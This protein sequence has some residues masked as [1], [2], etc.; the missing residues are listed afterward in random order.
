MVAECDIRS[1]PRPLL[2]AHYSELIAAVQD[3]DAGVPLGEH[4]NELKTYKDRFAGVLC[5]LSSSKFTCTKILFVACE[6]C[7][8]IEWLLSW[9]FVTMREEGCQLS[10]SLLNEA[11][12]QPVGGLNKESFKKHSHWKKLA[13]VDGVGAFYRF[14]A[15]TPSKPVEQCFSKLSRNAELTGS[16]TDSGSECG[17]QTQ[18]GTSTMGQSGGKIVETTRQGFLMKK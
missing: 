15:L 3:P 11:Y 18:C 12:L 14:S 4:K 10:N 9:L 17:M 5:V 6:S 16:E 1:T 13:F 2:D 7:E 8:L